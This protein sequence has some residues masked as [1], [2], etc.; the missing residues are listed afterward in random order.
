M[1]FAREQPPI[2]T[3][4]KAGTLVEI[5]APVANSKGLSQMK[6]LPFVILT[7]SLFLSGCGAT[8]DPL[9]EL[10]GNQSKNNPPVAK[11]DV[12]ASSVLKRLVTA[13]GL[14]SSDKD[15]DPL[16][17][18]WSLTSPEGSKS[19]LATGNHSQALFT[20]DIIGEYQLA[21]F[22]SD[23]KSRS[24]IT[25]ERIQ[26]TDEKP[27]P[28]PGKNQ[29]ITLR[30]TSDINKNI[31]FTFATVLHEGDIDR[32]SGFILK[33]DKQSI[34]LQA[35]VKALYGDSS[36]KHVILS[37]VIPRLDK[38]SEISA[39]LQAITKTKVSPAVSLEQLKKYSLNS[40]AELI[41]ENK[42]YKVSVN[43]AL[44]SAN[45]V[46]KS[47]LR[48]N[49]V[50]EWIVYTPFSDSL[51]GQSHPHLSAVISVRVYGNF[52]NVLLSIAVENNWTYQES[53][54]NFSYNARININGQT[55]QY[56]NL[57]HSRA[58]RWRTSHWL[59]PAATL[60][61]EHDSE[62]LIDSKAVPSYD[63]NLIGRLFSSRDQHFRNEWKNGKV[64]YYVTK[65]GYNGTPGKPG[66]VHFRMNKIGPMGI[67]LAQR[68]MPRTGGRD[69]IGPLPSWAASYLLSQSTTSK[70]VMMGM[71]D[72]AA[73]WPIHFRDKNTLLPV[74]IN[75]YPYVAHH[76]RPS[77]SI[78]PDGRNYHTALC[79]AGLENCI[80][81]YTPDTAHQPSFAYLPYLISGD[82][83][84][85]EEL[86]FW[87]NY[88]FLKMNPVFREKEKGLFINDME[89]RGQAWS[90]R[91]LAQTAAITP[92]DHPL[93]NY[94]TEKLQY[95]I[96]RYTQEYVENSPNN[97]GMLKLHHA[98][99]LPWQDDFFT[100]SIGH[101]VDLGFTS[102]IS[103]RQ[104]KSAFSVK[105]MGF[106]NNQTDDYCWVFAAPYHLVASDDSGTT[107]MASIAD[108]YQAT[109]SN[110]T[111]HAPGKGKNAF[112][113]G[114]KTCASSEMTAALNH[115]HHTLKY[116]D[117]GYTV[118][119]PFRNYTFIQNEMQGYSRSAMG[120]PSN[121]QI[122]LATAV[123]ANIPQAEQAWARFL[124]RSVKPDYPEH[125]GL[126][127]NYR[128]T[129]NFAI[130]PRES[131]AE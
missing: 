120:F 5:A 105:R 81:P 23:G 98:I 116:Q 101:V 127:Y 35:N 108:I 130:V 50:N 66:T 61:I 13:S 89:D 62:Y 56:D 109:N 52:S 82:Y 87:A 15:N 40:T 94:F 71:A 90:M 34:P 6:Y 95:N 96:Q 46:I 21:L 126:L 24:Q 65:D 1:T 93:K 44:L 53:P 47:W 110:I 49:E 73:S 68:Y 45:S 10:P 72:L 67:G 123:D 11:I 70:Q 112:S 75:Q 29:T 77:V 32:N 7:S 63:K 48:G 43:D 76:K 8:E 88:N 117:N 25:R 121:L 60:H 114:N 102:A 119:S 28:N 17:Y 54:Q 4:F 118:H 9:S 111:P 19:Q 122:A 39:Q 86:H 85:L 42:N 14:R 59:K 36:A 2:S 31:P 12:S 18:H 69:D 30:N 124:S 129:P 33:S 58:S 38:G 100:W 79:K 22:V 106:S 92:D 104:W 113:D 64:D 51:T 37:G 99:S 107:A 83:F 78:A 16:S 131:V 26:V 57:V 3:H 20:P 80:S 128:G 84:L 125:A 103:L 91:T 115:F 41:A 97:Y 74:S 55:K 27:T